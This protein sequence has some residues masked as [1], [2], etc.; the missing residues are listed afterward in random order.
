LEHSSNFY[1]K[2]LFSITTQKNFPV[3]PYR[4]CTFLTNFFL[5]TLKFSNKKG[6]FD[7]NLAFTATLACTKRELHKKRR[8]L[9]VLWKKLGGTCPPRFPRPCFRTFF[10][11]MPIKTSKGF[12]FARN[13]DGSKSTWTIRQIHDKRFCGQPLLKLFF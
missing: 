1:V 13:A 8:A 5:K 3:I 12:V 9:F 2:P 6:T 10:T 11:P 7:V 4:N